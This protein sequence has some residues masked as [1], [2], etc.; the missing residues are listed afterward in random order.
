M[1]E[2]TSYASKAGRRSVQGVIKPAA[3]GYLSFTNLVE[4]FTLAAM[5]REHQVKL[6]QI[7]A[8][9]HLVEREL[10]VSPR[11]S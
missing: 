9:I 4:A 5:R 6:S 10:G 8:A 7:R 3:S 11:Q 1:G 2:R